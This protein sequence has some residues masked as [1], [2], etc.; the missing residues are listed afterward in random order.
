MRSGDTLLLIEAVGGALCFLAVLASAFSSVVL[1]RRLQRQLH[2]RYPELWAEICAAGGGFF[3]AGPKPMQIIKRMRTEAL[4]PGLHRIAR[5]YNRLVW[6][7]LV[8]MLA[9][10]ASS[11]A[12]KHLK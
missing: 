12:L 6:V 3:N 2:A 8:A 11:Y 7:Q 5:W 9:L 4:D 10:L 1:M